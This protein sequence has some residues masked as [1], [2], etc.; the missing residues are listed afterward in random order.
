MAK[1]KETKTQAQERLFS[2]YKRSFNAIPDFDSFLE[3]CTTPADKKVFFL[4][5]LSKITFTN[6]LKCQRK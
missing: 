2:A 5:R 1:I 6:T 3:S 4:P